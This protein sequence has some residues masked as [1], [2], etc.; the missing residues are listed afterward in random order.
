[1]MKWKL[2]RNELWG[3]TTFAVPQFCPWFHQLCNFGP[4]MPFFFFKLIS[5]LTSDMIETF[6]LWLSQALCFVFV[7]FKFYLC[8]IYSISWVMYDNHVFNFFTRVHNTCCPK[9]MVTNL[10]AIYSLR[11]GISLWSFDKLPLLDYYMMKRSISI[12]ILR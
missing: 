12:F 6:L 8:S 3:K 10:S 1:M 9:V 2:Y 7:T 4:G 11:W 5:L